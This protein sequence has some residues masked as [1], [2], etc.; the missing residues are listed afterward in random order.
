MTEASRR[1]TRMLGAAAIAVAS[2]LPAAAQT[3]ITHAQGETEIPA[4]PGTILAFDVGVI[5]TLDALGAAIAGVPEFGMPAYLDQYE[6]DEYIKIGTLFE[7]DYEAVNLADPDLIVVALR[8]STSYEQLAA[9]GPTID[10]TIAGD[11]LDGVVAN[12]NTLAEITGTTDTAAT[13]LAD[14][15]AAVESVRAAAADAGNALIV[16]ISGGAVT[17]YGPGSRFGW[18]HDDLGVVPAIEDVEAATH[19]DAISFEFILETDPDWLI[20]VDRDAAIG[21]EGTAAA[22]VLDNEIMAETTAWQ[23]ERVIYVDSAAW[24]LAGGGIQATLNAVNQLATAFAA[25]E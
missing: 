16:M 4:N 18:V 25:A 11:Y 23:N 20:V 15:D 3:V 7:P 2:A 5:D 22:E 19:G 10:L 9:I 17:A 12:T 6:S 14:L 1:M 24:Y 8:S 21:Q 13:L